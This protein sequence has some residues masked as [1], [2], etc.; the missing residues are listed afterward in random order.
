MEYNNFLANKK[1]VDIP[2]GFIVDNINDK[3]F[4][5]QKS[6]VKWALRRGRAAIFADCGLGKSAM[7]LEWAEKVLPFNPYQGDI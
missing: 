5:F 7:Q 4:S 6:V 1:I 2:S 3:L